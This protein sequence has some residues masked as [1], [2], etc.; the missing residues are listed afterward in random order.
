MNKEEEWDENLAKALEAIGLLDEKAAETILKEILS[1]SMEEDRRE[2]LKKALVC[3][4]EFE[5]E[6]AQKIINGVIK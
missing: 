6:E 5:Y 2:A 1:H 4:K 3:I